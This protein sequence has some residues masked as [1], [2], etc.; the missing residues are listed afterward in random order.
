MN[1]QK[2]NQKEK[3]MGFAYVFLLFAAITTA[4]CLLLFYYNSD[5]LKFTQKNFAIAKMS[6]MKEYQDSQSQAATMVDSLYNKINKFQPMVTAVY[7]ENDI[8]FMINELKNIYDQH[9]WDV[10]YKSFN[11]VSLFYAMWF[12]DKKDLWAKRDN[13]T[14]IKR[15]LEECEI[16]LQNKKNDLMLSSK[17]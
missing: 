6:R 7:E 2:M 14:H 3:A 9:A 13:I 15:N 5:F 16:G 11:H 17:K 10:R 8:M 1:G 12:D 4:C